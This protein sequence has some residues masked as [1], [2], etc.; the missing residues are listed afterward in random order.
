MAVTLKPPRVHNL[1]SA[2]VKLQQRAE[3]QPTMNPKH[4]SLAQMEEPAPV[5]KW[6]SSLLS[7]VLFTSLFLVF[8]WACW[9]TVMWCLGG[10]KCGI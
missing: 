7:P 3:K 1:K 2:H 6:K 8:L 10:T 4:V 9:K 5:S